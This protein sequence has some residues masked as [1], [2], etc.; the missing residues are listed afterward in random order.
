MQ[1]Q[2][3]ISEDIQLLI[4]CYLTK[5]ITST[6]SLKLQEWIESDP[7][8][9]QLFQ[10][11]TSSWLVTSNSNDQKH[12]DIPSLWSR[13]ER[14]INSS[15]K[16]TVSISKAKTKMLSRFQIAASWFIS[17]C[18][19]SLFTWYLTYEP[20]E[21]AI[22][23]TEYTVPKGSKSTI[24]LPD[25]STVWLNAGSRIAY[26]SDFDKKERIVYLSGEAYFA[27]ATNKNKPFVVRTS[28][29]LVR[30]LGTRFNVKAYPD[31]KTITTTLEEGVIDIQ[32][33]NG[34]KKDN[35]QI[36]IKPNEKL[37]FY[38]SGKV[39]LPVDRS[40]EKVQKI[41]VIDKNIKVEENIN[42]ELYTSWKSDK[43]IIEGVTL[44]RLATML[45]RRYNMTI[46][47]D[48]DG[49]E[50]YKFTGIIENE[51]IEQILNALRYTAP[52]KYKIEKDTIYLSVD[53]KLKS[54]F[55]RI[56]TT[57]NNN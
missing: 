9:S 22:K 7:Y 16:P 52:L 4:V 36:K 18:I 57:R 2:T 51:T 54:N 24:K 29:I 32:V 46:H 11:F 6:D 3:Y 56:I 53:P 17:I 55:E 10:Q 44:N 34:N 19:G 12:I 27:V 33:I 26:F 23:T 13:I 1:N 47:F 15:E 49:L 48:N 35:P 45:E 25:G 8:N 43:W 39:E 38:K 21:S 37:V 28:D 20:V 30:A 5:T 40:V 14:E 41:Q 50:Q 42:T 31:E